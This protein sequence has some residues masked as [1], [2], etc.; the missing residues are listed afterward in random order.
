M[1]TRLI[2]FDSLPNPES[3]IVKKSGQIY[4]SI[5]WDLRLVSSTP[6]I[7]TVSGTYVAIQGTLESVTYVR[8]YV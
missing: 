1:T 2:R 7:P 8:T 6:Y 4:Y 5:V 3:G